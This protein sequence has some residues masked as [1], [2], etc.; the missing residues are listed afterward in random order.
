MICPSR[1]R[2]FELFASSESEEFCGLSRYANLAN[3]WFACLHTCVKPAL[4]LLFFGNLNL[5]F[6]VKMSETGTENIEFWIFRC[7]SEIMSSLRVGKGKNRRIYGK[8]IV[9]ALM[10]PLF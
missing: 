1:Q 10:A 7:R 3:F 2:F 5:N 8:F 4:I 9:L 6:E